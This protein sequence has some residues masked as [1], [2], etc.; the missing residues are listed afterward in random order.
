MRRLERNGQRKPRGSKWV[1][2]LFATEYARDRVVDYPDLFL[3]EHV[4]KQRA[5]FINITRQFRELV[6]FIDIEIKVAEE[7][8]NV[9]AYD[10][11]P[12][13]RNIEPGERCSQRRA[14]REYANSSPNQSVIA[15]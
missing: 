10:I 9:V 1:M 7:N 2:S 6:R 14:P 5:H 3:I 12:R 8:V 13:A 11:T 15:R 4:H